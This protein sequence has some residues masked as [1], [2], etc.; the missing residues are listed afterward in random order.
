MS[1][2]LFW[3]Q[4]HQTHPHSYLQNNNHCFSLKEILKK[5]SSHSNISEVPVNGHKQTS[6]LTIA[7]A[8][9]R[10][11]TILGPSSVNKLAKLSKS[12]KCW[13]KSAWSTWNKLATPGRVKLDNTFLIR[14]R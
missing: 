2:Q 12:F 7:N 13:M 9:N 8:F 14:L 4:V 1:Y 6:K 11:F 3:F 5:R 10:Y